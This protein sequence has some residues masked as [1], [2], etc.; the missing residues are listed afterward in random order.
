MSHF[1]DIYDALKAI[2]DALGGAK[3]VGPRLRPGFDGSAHWVLNCCNREHAQ[4]FA[5]HHTVQLRAW[6]CEIGYHD[7]KH[8]QDNREGY[9][10][11]V[12]LTIESQIAA[13]LKHTANDRRRLEESE[14]NLR[15]LA[16]NPAFA[17]WAEKTGV[18]LEDLA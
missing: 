16:G 11:A 14:R 15:D 10:P 13:I 3:K 12:P 17:A 1:D 7:A 8:W 9:Q 5:P 4:N 6:A 18:K 2:V